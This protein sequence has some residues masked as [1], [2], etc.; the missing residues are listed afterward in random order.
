QEFVGAL[1]YLLE[2]VPLTCDVSALLARWRWFADC[3]LG[4]VGILKDWLVQTV[5][6]TLGEA[7]SALTI[8]A[9]MQHALQP[10]QRVRLEVEARAGEQ[11]VEV[12]NATSHEQLQALLGIASHVSHASSPLPVPQALPEPDTHTARLLDTRPKEPA[13]RRG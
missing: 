12:G 10:A 6:A 4:C 9:L 2:H 11:K 3:S 1:R 13:R 5:A 8:E 7:G